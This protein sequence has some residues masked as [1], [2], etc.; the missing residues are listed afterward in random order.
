[1]LFTPYRADWLI[2]TDELQRFIQ[3]T[4]REAGLRPEEVDSGAVILTGVALERANARAVADLFAN[5]GGKLVCASAGHNLEAILAAHGS[6]AVALSRAR[7]E[8]L[9]HV[10]SGG[11]PATPA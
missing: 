6:G 4:Y 11:A 5:E 3:R 10:D 8:R 1:I 7:R 2:D 9:L